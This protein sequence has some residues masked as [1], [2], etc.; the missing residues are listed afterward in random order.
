MLA[1]ANIKLEV[2]NHA[3]GGFGV[4]PSH[5]C[6]HTM[7]G[8][9]LDLLTWDFQMMAPRGDCIVEN[10]A[11]A[12]LNM[13]PR[14]AIMFWQGGV[15]LPKNGKFDQSNVRPI[16]SNIK[17]SC[18]GKWMVDWYADL[19]SHYGDL[20]SVLQYLRYKGEHPALED[21]TDSLFLDPEKGKR[22]STDLDEPPFDAWK[23]QEQGRRRLARHHPG[24]TLHRIWGLAWAHAYLGLLIEGLE[25]FD[26]SSLVTAVL[27][28]PP[29][30]KVKGCKP[31]YCKDI[32]PICSTTLLPRV[33]GAA[34]FLESMVVGKNKWRMVDGDGRA[35]VNKKFGYV[36]GKKALNGDVASGPL[37]VRFTTTEDKLPLAIC[38]VPCPWGRC[39]GGRVILEGNAAFMLDEVE[40]PPSG[41][42]TAASPG[43]YKV[44]V[45]KDM[46][47]VIA[48][49]VSKGTHTLTITP[50]APEG[51]S[52]IVS[53]LIYF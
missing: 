52:I 38:Q 1:E 49:E 23:L 53:H 24:P 11:R 4:M 30:I 16:K 40:L 2:R 19:G 21:G 20:A 34:P 6:V 13:P 15:W 46:C 14:P 27:E 41:F 39:K 48:K 26:Q 42:A 12:A 36:D 44:L 33:E 47:F 50:T 43:P 18:G 22:P 5:L 25:T 29:E 8:R 17:Q 28:P 37:Q 31:S 10:F 51:S 7:V 3:V 9:D 32:V 35:G 45:Q